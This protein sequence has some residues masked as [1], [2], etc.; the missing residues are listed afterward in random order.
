MGRCIRFLLRDVFS[1]CPHCCRRGW[2][3]LSSAATQALLE[4]EL[5]KLFGKRHMEHDIAGLRTTT[6]CGAGRVGNSVAR[7]LRANRALSLWLKPL[8]PALQRSTPNGLS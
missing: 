7:E 1:D 6:H 4:F 8:E 2:F 5:S 3:F